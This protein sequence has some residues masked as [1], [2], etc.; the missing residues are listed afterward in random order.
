MNNSSQLDQNSTQVLDLLASDNYREDLNNPEPKGE[1][2]AL[3]N[4]GQL[5]LRARAAERIFP[6]KTRDRLKL[7]YF[8]HINILVL[9]FGLYFGEIFEHE[10]VA[11]VLESELLP[12]VSVLVVAGGVLYFWQR[13]NL[14]FPQ[15]LA[16]FFR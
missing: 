2:V 13:K 7:K 6:R 3:E 5:T 16:R 15:F 11:K 14:H 10:V 8:Y 1:L 9:L 4:P 12:K